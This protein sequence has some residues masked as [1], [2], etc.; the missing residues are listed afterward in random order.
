[1]VKA[2]EVRVLSWAPNRR[3]RTS[4]IVLNNLKI[5]ELSPIPVQGRPGACVGIRKNRWY[6]CWYA[7]ATNKTD[8]NMP[9]TDMEI[10]TAKPGA[11]LAKLSDGGGLQLW[12]MPDGAKRW[13]LA[14]RLA[15]V[16]KVL[17]IGVYPATGLREARD[18]RDAA[19][20][21]LA[22]GQTLRWPRDSPSSRKPRLP[23]IPSTPSPSSFWKRSAGSKR[24]NARS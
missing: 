21:L 6:I 2:V 3:S 15:G 8:T 12:I 9:L 13:R 18:S 4:E 23:R 11:R 1:M 10:R 7:V 19:R 17:A 16:Q 24:R 20:K 5:K 14:Y 22:I